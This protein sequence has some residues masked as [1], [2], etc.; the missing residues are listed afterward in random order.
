MRRLFFV[1]FVAL[2]ILPTSMLSAVTAQEA[3]PADMGSGPI[4][5][6]CSAPKSFPVRQLHLKNSSPKTRRKLHPLVV[7]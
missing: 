5:D 1:A 4:T 3:T 6:V 2:W 7:A